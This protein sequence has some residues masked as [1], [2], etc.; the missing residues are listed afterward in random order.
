MKTISILLGLMFSFSANAELKEQAKNE[1]SWKPIEIQLGDQARAA[2]GYVTSDGRWRLEAIAPELE[3]RS[4]LQSSY[5]AGLGLTQF[6]K[7]C[8]RMGFGF[9]TVRELKRNHSIVLSL[10]AWNEAVN[11]VKGPQALRVLKVRS[12]VAFEAKSNT[13][14]YGSINPREIERAIEAQVQSQTNEL[15]TT[16]SIAIDIS[17]HDYLACDFVAGTA[18]LGL[19]VVWEYPAAKLKRQPII[20]A[21]EIAAIA[22]EAR[23]AYGGSGSC[24]DRVALSSA[25]LAVAMNSIAKRSVV[26]MGVDRY[27]EMFNAVYDT[28]SCKWRD[29]SAIQ[30]AAVAKIFDVLSEENTQAS[31]RVMSR[32]SGVI[33]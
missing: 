26:E 1:S 5:A 21:E 7:H 30:P 24:L 20:R 12:R 8:G 14:M 6:T 19:E 16:G 23:S 17:G 28:N 15:R 3:V 9:S 32:F 27:A 11:G 22:N 29:G 18:H 33:K 25:V 13:L 31:V 4:S 10:P 2:T